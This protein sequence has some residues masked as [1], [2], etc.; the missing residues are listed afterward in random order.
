MGLFVTVA[1]IRCGEDGGVALASAGHPPAVVLAP[2]GEVR[3]VDIGGVP[4]GVLDDERYEETVLGP[5]EYNV[6][7]LYSD[8]LT[9]ARN[10]AGEMYGLERLQSL[11][12][13]LAGGDPDPR[14]VHRA[15]LEDLERFAG[16]VAQSDDLTVLVV[17]RNP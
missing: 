13:S 17:G 10:V 2:G 8:G 5:E 1:L 11:L 16:G 3:L 12:G 9:E 6:I 7:V 4:L 15:I 14:R